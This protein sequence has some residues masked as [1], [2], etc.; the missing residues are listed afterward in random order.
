MSIVIEWYLLGEMFKVVF[1][2]GLLLCKDGV[3][4][5]THTQIISAATNLY[6]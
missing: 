5:T 6:L 4:E 2:L 1:N 3:Y